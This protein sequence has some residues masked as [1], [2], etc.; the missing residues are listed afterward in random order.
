MTL[1]IIS[2][3]KMASNDAASGF[4]PALHDGRGGSGG[5]GRR[6][7]LAAAARGGVVLVRRR[8]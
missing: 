2:A 6:R 8:E 3:G 5:D 7:G 4:C 1:R